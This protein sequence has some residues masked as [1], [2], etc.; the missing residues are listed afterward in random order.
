MRY[1]IHEVSFAE[2]FQNRFPSQVFD[3][4]FCPDV[5]S[6]P[7]IMKI[8]SE[9][10]MEF[11]ALLTLLSVTVQPGRM[12]AGSQGPVVNSWVSASRA[13]MPHLAAVDR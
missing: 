10:C 8:K 12:A 6:L 4:T 13:L 9:Y 3:V 2:R 7:S 11:S 5:A 1:A